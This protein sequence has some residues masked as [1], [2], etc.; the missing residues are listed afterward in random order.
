MTVNRKFT[1]SFLIMA[2]LICTVYN[3]SYRMG[4]S[5]NPETETEIELETEMEMEQTE[6][7]SAAAKVGDL[8]G[9]YKYYLVE[10]NGMVYVYL[11]DKKTLYEYTTIQ[12]ESLP[13]TLQEEIK[14]GKF[15]KSD[16]ELYDFLENY[17]S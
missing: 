4:A 2:V 5:G 10:E 16:K 15:L 6:I 9:M 13:K 8:S 1:I 12:M 14:E 3:F 11:D 7:L 17:S